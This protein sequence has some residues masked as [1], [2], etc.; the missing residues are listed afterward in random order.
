MF[1]NSVIRCLFLAFL[2]CMLV[3]ASFGPFNT[4]SAVFAIS[5]SW[6][7]SAANRRAPIVGMP[8][9]SKAGYLGYQGGANLPVA[10]SNI[11]NTIQATAFGVK[12]D[13]VT[14]SSAALQS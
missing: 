4:S 14:D 3:A 5:G 6:D 8:D 2:L 9:W 12:G 13:G 11:G 1:K 7:L 10:A